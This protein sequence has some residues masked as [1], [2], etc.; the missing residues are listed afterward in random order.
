MSGTEQKRSNALLLTLESWIAY[1]PLPNF[2]LRLPDTQPSM[3]RTPPFPQDSKERGVGVHH[4]CWGHKGRSW[5][6]VS[7]VALA[8]GR[9]ESSSL[10]G[11]V[12]GG[13]L[14]EVAWMLQAYAN[15]PWLTEG[16]V[17]YYL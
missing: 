6:C 12:F 14:T 3:P 10:S 9:Q 17:I 16:T 13:N 8:A 2:T 11:F 4:G 5:A 7:I 15:N 1:S